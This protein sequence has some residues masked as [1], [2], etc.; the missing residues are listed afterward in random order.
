[1]PSIKKSLNNSQ[2]TNKKTS[3]SHLPSVV[4][5]S[6]F[7]Y[8]ALHF[9]TAWVEDLPT[10]A[11]FKDSKGV[12]VDRDGG[13]VESDIIQRLIELKGANSGIIKIQVCECRAVSNI[14]VE[15]DPIQE[16]IYHALVIQSI[17]NDAG[18]VEKKMILTDGQAKKLSRLVKANSHYIVKKFEP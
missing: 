9:P 2:V 14:E 13:R 12:S 18:D 3:Q 15:A 8:R 10:S 17:I 1:M 4:D 11:A 6:E 16:N 5:D 7:I